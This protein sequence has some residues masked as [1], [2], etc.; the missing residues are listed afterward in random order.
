MARLA[1]APITP[2]GKSR[3]AITVT[4]VMNVSIERISLL[5]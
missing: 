1:K 3:F 2:M 4:T 5:S